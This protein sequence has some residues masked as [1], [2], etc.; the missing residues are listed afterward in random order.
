VIHYLK[1]MLPVPL[2]DGPFAVVVEPPPAAVSV[3]G[4]LGLAAVVLTATAL[5]IRRMEIRYTE[6]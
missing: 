5:I 4:L 6:D 3:L 2:S 1:G